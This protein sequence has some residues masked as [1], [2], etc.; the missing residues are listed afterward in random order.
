MNR[1]DLQKQPFKAVEKPTP[2]TSACLRTAMLTAWLPD[3][4]LK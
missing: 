4:T 1:A 2:T 3:R